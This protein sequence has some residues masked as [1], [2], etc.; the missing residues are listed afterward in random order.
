MH[1]LQDQIARAAQGYAV[2]RR[3]SVRVGLGLGLDQI[4][5]PIRQRR[6][7]LYLCSG[8]TNTAKSGIFPSLSNP[9]E[10]GRGLLQPCRCQMIS[11][12]QKLTYQPG[13]VVAA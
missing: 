4:M 1:C 10:L 7:C 13:L 11:F 2:W 8:G 5:L 12:L 3:V 9:P 6:G